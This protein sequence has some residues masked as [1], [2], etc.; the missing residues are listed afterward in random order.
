LRVI[1]NKNIQFEEFNNYLP[2]LNGQIKK[3]GQFR[4]AG[5]DDFSPPSNNPVFPN[6]LNITDESSDIDKLIMATSVFMKKYLGNSELGL[7]IYNEDNRTY[8]E[9]N[10][11]SNDLKSFVSSVHKD[12]LIDWLIETGKPKILPDPKST[13]INGTSTNYLLYHSRQDLKKKL[14]VFKLDQGIS[15]V[16]INGHIDIM[17]NIFR[18]FFIKSEKLIL[19]KELKLLYNELHLY[20]SKLS[21]DFKLS[22]I[23]ELTSGIV[24]EILTPLQIILSN[25]EFL[26]SDD[27]NSPFLINIKDQV[28]K[29]ENLVNRVLKFAN[30]QDCKLKLNSVNINDVLVNYF[31]MISSSLESE[32]YECLLNLDK[33]IPS[34]LSNSVYLN[35]IFSNIFSI[36]RNSDKSK[37][38]GILIQTK[39]KDFSIQVRIVLTKKLKDPEKDDDICQEYKLLKNFM[40]K[41]EGGI[42]LENIKNS[43]SSIILTF[44]LKRRVR[45]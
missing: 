11:I 45:Q 32:K 18:L 21:N 38:G 28:K 24:E 43:G 5:K 2:I 23:G 36:I 30:I 13:K 8:C 6:Y 42:F 35:Q 15:E 26:N 44:P 16:K 31:N 27:L 7:F 22:A 10:Q 4:L 9:V 37:G 12:A 41:H 19:E 17:E 14:I 29:V 34:I 40:G 3:N 1:K 39:Y 20:Q 33:N 25:A